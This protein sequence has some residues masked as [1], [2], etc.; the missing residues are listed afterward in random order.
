MSQNFARVVAALGTFNGKLYA[1]PFKAS[2]KSLLWYN[3]PAFKAAGVTAAEDVGAAA[4]DG[5]DAEGVGHAGVLDRRL[6]RLDAHRPV[7][8]HLPAHVRHAKYNQ[9]AAHK[10]KWTD[11]TVTKA[12]KTMG[13]I[14]GDSSNLAG[15]TSGALQYGFN[16]S[17]TNAFAS[18]PKAAMVFEGDFVSGVIT[19][20]DEGE[21]RKRLQRGAVPVD[22]A[23]RRL[24]GGR[25]LGRPVRHVPRQPRRSRRS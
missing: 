9:L 6:G 21:G 24:D 2:N 17:V 1:L 5:E 10:I 19:V 13:Q 15:G 22:H 4:H 23:R 8:E 3:V 25:D 18:P 12:L 16:D 11:P 20:V 14:L 7:R